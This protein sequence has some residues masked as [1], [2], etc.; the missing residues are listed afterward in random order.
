ML[1]SSFE[2]MTFCCFSWA[3]TL[4]RHQWVKSN[5]KWTYIQASSVGAHSLPWLG[6][7]RV[8][9]WFELSIDQQT[10][11][12]APSSGLLLFTCSVI[13]APPTVQSQYKKDKGSTWTECAHSSFL[14][15]QLMQQMKHLFFSYYLLAT[16]QCKTNTN[17]CVICFTG[18][19]L[20][21]I[22]ILPTVITLSAS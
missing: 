14:L 22:K 6:P 4:A 18:C 16:V 17:S 21:F 12:D 7:Y 13:S 2:N 11:E 10:W 15:K 19:S 3:S 5:Q 20:S 9:V 8:T 1:T